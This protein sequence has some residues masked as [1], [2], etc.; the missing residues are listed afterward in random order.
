M[1]LH[2]RGLS[3]LGLTMA[4]AAISG[5]IASP[6]AAQTADA[7]AVAQ[8]VEA[9]SRAMIAVDR[10]QLEALSS[11]ALS[12]GHSAGRIEN[13]AQFIANLEA[14]TAAFRTINLTDQTVSISGGDAIVRHT[15]TGETVSPAGQ[16]TPVRIGVLQ[17]WRK[18]GSTW[19]LLARQAF[20]L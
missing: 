19:R 15:F 4:A 3:A 20:R 8:A 5:A 16:V 14:R 12:Y 7:A 17:V 18:E 10:A 2:R 13:K 11:D 6:A 9:L 1:Q